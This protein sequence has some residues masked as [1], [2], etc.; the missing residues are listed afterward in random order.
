MRPIFTIDMTDT[1]VIKKKIKEMLIGFGI[2][3]F[4]L[5]AYRGRDKVEISHERDEVDGILLLAALQEWDV[6]GEGETEKEEEWA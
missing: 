1:E 3:P 4:L 5:I 2:E 6:G